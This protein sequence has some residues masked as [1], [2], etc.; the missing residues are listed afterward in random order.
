MTDLQS[1]PPTAQDL[2]N[3]LANISAEIQ[4]QRSRMATGALGDLGD[5]G[6]LLTQMTAMLGRMNPADAKGCEAAL[7]QVNAELGKVSE[8]YKRQR[9][10]AQAGM[11]ELSTRMRAATAYT[12]RNLSAPAAPLTL[13]PTDEDPT[14][15]TSSSKK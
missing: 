9:D 3:L 11:S 8:A 12:Q 2:A 1:E 7:D 4:L 6:P 14:R 15:D 5:L 13:I 10:E